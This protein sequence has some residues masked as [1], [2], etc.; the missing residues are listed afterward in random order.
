MKKL[1]FIL[2]FLLIGNFVF[3]QHYGGIYFAPNWVIS[4]DGT[5]FWNKPSK[6]LQTYDYTFGY[7]FGYQGLI[8]PERRFSFSY[9]IQYSYQVVELKFHT[10]VK[11]WHDLNHGTYYYYG[12]KESRH[13]IEIPATWRYNILKNRKIQP[14]VSVSTTLLIPIKKDQYWIKENG[15]L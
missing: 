8:M 1:L 11:E 4:G 10:P 12:M 14:Y 3:A 2:S 6:N 7:T 13:A 5:P 15:D 9:G